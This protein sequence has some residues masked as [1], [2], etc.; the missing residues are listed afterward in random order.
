M[1]NPLKKNINQEE[2]E[3]VVTL[4]WENGYVECSAKEPRIL[5]LIGNRIL[6]GL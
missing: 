5:Y 2:T 6:K 1:N 4:D 3:A